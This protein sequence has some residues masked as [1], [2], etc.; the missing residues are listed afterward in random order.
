MEEEIKKLKEENKILKEQL[1]NFIPRR[2]IRRVFKQ[3][4]KILE[5][6]LE[7]ENKEHIQKLKEFI[8]KIEKE[9]QQIAGQDI[10]GAIEH[11]LSLIDLTE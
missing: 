4:K 5:Q 9:G 7:N 8:K 2:R 10:K 11:L 6:D 1:D 3:L